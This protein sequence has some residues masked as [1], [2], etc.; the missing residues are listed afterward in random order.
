MQSPAQSTV[1]PSSL[2][3]RLT[4]PAAAGPWI[5][6][7]LASLATLPRS[8][9]SASRLRVSG[10]ER[11]TARASSRDRERSLGWLP[12]APSASAAEAPAGAAA[13]RKDRELLTA[14]GSGVSSSTEP[15]Q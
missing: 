13:S 9:L 14:V 12:G 1:Y 4:H 11:R 15:L 3:V 2:G 5:F 7:S 10:K 8:W 6:H